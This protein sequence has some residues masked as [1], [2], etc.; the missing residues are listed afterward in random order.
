[1]NVFSLVVLKLVMTVISHDDFKDRSEGLTPTVHNQWI[2]N[3]H[4]T[5]LH[6]NAIGG[7]GGERLVIEHLKSQRNH[8][9]KPNLGCFWVLKMDCKRD[10]HA[11]IAL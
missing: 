2:S 1:M 10:H 4:P 6:F 5:T 8:V 11:P 7:L 3:I 9:I